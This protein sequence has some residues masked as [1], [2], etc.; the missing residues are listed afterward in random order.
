[1]HREARSEKLAD[2]LSYSVKLFLS[3]TALTVT[4]LSLNK[5]HYFHLMC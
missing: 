2:F 4:L 1:M 5:Q 3:L